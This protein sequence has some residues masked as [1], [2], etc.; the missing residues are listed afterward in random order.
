MNDSYKNKN[1]FKSLPKVQAA[2]KH[3]KN[4]FSMRQL[5]HFCKEKDF[6][7]LIFL[8]CLAGPNSLKE[9]LNGK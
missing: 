3:I 5:S 2:K 6:S 1:G 9:N 7:G 8:F 4:C